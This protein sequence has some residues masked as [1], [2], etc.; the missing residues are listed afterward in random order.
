MTN[1]NLIQKD[2]IGDLNLLGPNVIEASAGTGK[3]YTI[4]GL[5]IRLLLGDYG[6]CGFTSKNIEPL[7]IEEILVITFTNAATSDLK[8][9]IREKIHEVRLKFTKYYSLDVKDFNEFFKLN[10]HHEDDLL[11][12]KLLT[13]ILNSKDSLELA[14]RRLKTAEK[15]MDLSAIS[16]IHRFCH[17]V[18][19]KFLTSTMISGNSQ[20]RRDISDLTDEALYRAKAYYFYKKAISPEAIDIIKQLDDNV[21]SN[22]IKTF[23]IKNADSLRH[24]Y[25]FTEPNGNLKKIRDIDEAIDLSKEL[26]ESLLTNEKLNEYSRQFFINLFTKIGYSTSQYD[27]VIKFFEYAQ[28]TW[29]FLQNSEEELSKGDFNSE[30]FKELISVFVGD[31]VNFLVTLDI[32]SARN[33]FS[34]GQKFNLFGILPSRRKLHKE[35]VNNDEYNSQLVIDE[36]V[37]FLEKLHVSALGDKLVIKIAYDLIL[38]R[39]MQITEQ[40]KSKENIITN[41]DLLFKLK[42]VINRN[43]SVKKALQEQVLNIYPVAIIDEFQDT[44]PV[45]F[46]VFKNIYIDAFKQENYLPSLQENGVMQ[47]FYIVGD[48]KQSIYAFRDAEIKCYESA[49]GEIKAIDENRKY[50]L[51]TNYRSNVDLVN[52]VNQLFDKKILDE[53]FPNEDSINH[54]KGIYD[55]LN[56]KPSL[57]KKNANFVFIH[58]N[59]NSDN[60]ANL[61]NFNLPNSLIIDNLEHPDFK[62]FAP[63]QL[64]D[65][66]LMF[67]K[68]NKV[69]SK[70]VFREAVSIDTGLKIIELLKYGMISKKTADGKYELRP[71]TVDDIAILVRDV[72]EYNA[73][74]KVLEKF[75]LPTTYL[76]EKRTIDQTEEFK[77]FKK[78]MIAVLDNKDQAALKSLL[79]SSFFSLTADEYVEL[80]TGSNHERILNSLATAK[81]I[82]N[83]SSVLGMF[84]YFTFEK[85]VFF[86]D[87]SIKSHILSF[88]G[89]KRILANLMQCAELALFIGAKLKSIESIIPLFEK[90]E[91][92]T[93]DNALEND[94]LM[95]KLRLPEDKNVLRVTTYHSS[96]GLEYP[97][98]FLP[99]AGYISGKN[100]KT[101]PFKI[102][103]YYDEEVKEK[104]Y[105]LNYNQD[106]EEISK[107]D[108]EKEEARVIYVALTRASTLMYLYSSN[109]NND[110]ES[111]YQKDS[112]S[113]VTFYQKIARSL[114][115]PA[116]EKIAT[117]EGIEEFENAFTNDG[118]KLFEVSKV[119]YEEDLKNIDY[120][121][122]RYNKKFA[123]DSVYSIKVLEKE[124]IDD[125]WHISSYS[126][127]SKYISPTTITL[128]DTSKLN[129]ELATTVS[130]NVAN[131]EAQEDYL[132][133][134]DEDEEQDLLDDKTQIE[135]VKESK[136][137]SSKKK[138]VI[139]ICKDEHKLYNRHTFPRGANPGTFLH[140][141]MEHLSFSKIKE[142][143]KLEYVSS[144]VAKELLHNQINSF[145][146][147]KD[148]NE[149]T[150]DVIHNK[151]HSNEPFYSVVHWVSNIL[152]TPIIY[153]NEEAY[154][155]SDI[156]DNH[157]LKELEFLMSIDNLNTD[158]L[159]QIIENYYFKYDKAMYELVKNRRVSLTKMQG[160][161]NGF[162]DLIVCVNKKFYVIDYK[163]NYIGT[164]ISDYTKNKIMASIVEHRYDLQYILYTVALVRFLKQR[165]G[166]QFN[167][168]N[169]V[170]GVRYLFLR[171]MNGAFDPKV[172]DKDEGFGVFNTSLKEELIIE[173]E[174]LL[175]N[176]N[177]V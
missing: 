142:D 93:E 166:K 36:Y 112:K 34:S 102:I 2:V 5:V 95:S 19:H 130:S 176:K 133:K 84:E 59:A 150:F 91:N 81:E 125:S 171:G 127:L 65:M 111:R 145:W 82:W 7:Q 42:Y 26:F 28:D 151:K 152:K 120:Q 128:T 165:Y 163:S 98:V 44:D 31:L 161:I 139:V 77:S 17:N 175:T 108:E 116:H 131:Y 52:A 29:K 76:S 107:R 147:Y 136:T 18:L 45:Q 132:T 74:A 37:H 33:F 69:P 53:Y 24:A 62:R 32:E 153:D 168:A 70:N 79:L 83:N 55:S 27:P 6:N 103:K 85:G 167:Y 140:A 158:K 174:N 97:I 118:R 87:K 13:G 41:D 60:Q 154:S 1:T 143:D 49:V 169:L 101:E 67:T 135:L 99:F 4:T 160:F 75:N 121:N 38:T 113:N 155:L 11:V 88:A 149:E 104:V 20:L 124:F 100:N 106:G 51:Q 105:D 57:G 114:F 129:N 23:S 35:V 115:G 164:N 146:Q 72:K 63:C 172:S 80:T 159:N 78:L 47:G 89:G 12:K 73:F 94:N 137:E 46:S 14:I 134:I 3:T 58:K 96:K 25:I 9:K 40:I 50:F 86:K 109:F 15:N 126:S 61:D 123:D 92:N 122:F 157:C 71:I 64:V 119:D 110:V 16:T 8:R 162:I 48:P 39:A 21:M 170:G 141:V 148:E 138:Q 10:A 56:F 22:A 177:T 68:D 156:D 144:V 173:I 43:E 54:L 90:I 117:D 30:I 66:T